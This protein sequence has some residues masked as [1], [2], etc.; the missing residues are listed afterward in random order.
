M[1]YH[2]K[3]EISNSHF[4]KRK[5]KDEILTFL[6]ALVSIIMIDKKIN[7]VIAKTFISYLSS[8]LGKPEFGIHGYNL[9]FVFNL[10]NKH[11]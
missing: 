2:G 5:N 1:T 8:H 3:R 11:H 6:T 7:I 9:Q 10:L 4:C